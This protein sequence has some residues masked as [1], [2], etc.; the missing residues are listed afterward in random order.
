MLAKTK[1]IPPKVVN[2]INAGGL[3]ALLERTSEACLV[4]SSCVRESRA[5][6]R[7]WRRVK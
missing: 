1:T 6:A 3:F 7:T 4:R 2:G 5:A